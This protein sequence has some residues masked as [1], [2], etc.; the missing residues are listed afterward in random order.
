MFGL[1]G[2]GG[3]IGGWL[4]GF[5]GGVELIGLDWRNICFFELFRELIRGY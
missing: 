3:A 4:R 2:D 5:R 1:G